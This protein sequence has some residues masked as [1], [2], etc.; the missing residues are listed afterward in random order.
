MKKNTTYLFLFALFGLMAHATAQKNSSFYLGIGKATFTTLNTPYS[1]QLILSNGSSTRTFHDMRGMKGLNLTA[2]YEHQIHRRFS[3]GGN[4]KVI[5]VKSSGTNGFG[6][7][8]VN[9]KP[10][11]AEFP[12]ERDLWAGLAQAQLLYDF[13]EGDDVTLKLGAGPSAAFSKFQYSSYTTLYLQ[14][15]GQTSFSELS[16]TTKQ[17]SGLGYTF[18]LSLGVALPKSL[19]LLFQVM[20]HRIDTQR[21]TTAEM[22]VGLK[23]YGNKR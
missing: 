19:F 23:L 10:L 5:R 12:Y 2:G 18:S 17:R 13:L 21:Y 6:G 3:V 1:E 22:G 4:L 16:T 14:D 15:D 8:F 9:G 11:E 20:H 7:A